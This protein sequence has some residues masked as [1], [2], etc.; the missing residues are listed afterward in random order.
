MKVRHSMV[1]HVQR[2]DLRHA[3]GWR[4]NN[5]LTC[6]CTVAESADEDEPHE[7]SEWGPFDNESD[8]ISVGKE[9][10]GT[11]VNVDITVK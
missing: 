4:K 3:H 5:S 11:K 7:E 9:G 6:V 2:V 10:S 1:Y 8:E